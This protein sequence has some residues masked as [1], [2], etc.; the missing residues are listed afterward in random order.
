MRYISLFS[1][2][3]AATVAWEPLE[4][5]DGRYLVSNNGDVYSKERNRL[6]SQHV[7]SNGYLYVMLSKRGKK[8][9][10]YVHRLVASTFIDRKHGN[11]VVNHINGIKTDNRVENLEWCTYSEN[12]AHAY[13]IGLKKPI[14]TTAHNIKSRKRVRGYSSTLGT[15]E[16]ESVISAM[17]HGYKHVSE[18][19]NGHL[20][21]CGGYKWEVVR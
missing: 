13:R 5:Y 20:K 7:N 8:K 16:F 6:L 2:I 14:Q 9:R 15:V 19:I 3:E 4:E 11:I 10:H 18:C 21:T 17:K 1:G 12:N